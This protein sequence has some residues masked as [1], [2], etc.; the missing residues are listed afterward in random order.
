MVTRVEK[1]PDCY[2]CGTFGMASR[3]AACR[4][5]SRQIG[6]L[7]QATEMHRIADFGTIERFPQIIET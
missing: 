7:T 1:R 5:N 3:M 4:L 2:G 6:S